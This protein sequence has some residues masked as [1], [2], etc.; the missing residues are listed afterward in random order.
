MSWRLKVVAV[1]ALL[2]ASGCGDPICD[3]Q[4]QE[5]VVA[6]YDSSTNQAVAGVAVSSTPAVS[7]TCTE[8]SDRTECVAVGA[9][10]GAMELVVTA[11]GYQTVNLSGEVHEPNPE[12]VCDCGGLSLTVP[13]NSQ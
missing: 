13:L 5:V 2:G 8:Y 7:F 4:A 11:P 12:M 1:A 10:Y 3:C 9:P 6:V